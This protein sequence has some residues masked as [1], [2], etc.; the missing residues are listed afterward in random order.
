MEVVRSLIAEV[1]LVT[2]SGALQ[3]ELRGELAGILALCETRNS[4]ARQGDLAGIAE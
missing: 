3:V 2:E 1:R 4:N